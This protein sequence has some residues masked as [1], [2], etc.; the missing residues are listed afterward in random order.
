[1]TITETAQLIVGG[2]VVFTMGFIVGYMV[3]SALAWLRNE[4]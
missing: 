3:R 4:H 1:M 2:F